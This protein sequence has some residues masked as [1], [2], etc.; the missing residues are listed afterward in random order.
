MRLLLALLLFWL[1]ISEAQIILVLKKPAGGG[2]SGASFS[3]DFNRANSDSLGA[4]WTEVTGDTDITSNGM[5][6][7]NSGGS[8][9]NHWAVYS[10]T[11]TT[12]VDQYVKVTFAAGIA[13]DTYPQV[14]FR[15]TDASSAFYF[16]ELNCATN[17]WSWYRR[18]AAA[19]SSTQIGGTGDV[20][21]SC[22]SAS[23]GITL[24]GTATAT[25]FRIWLTPTGDAP[26][27]A[28]TWGGDNTPDI[29]FT[30]DPADAVDAGNYVGLGAQN[31]T[32]N[33]VVFDSFWG[34]D[35]P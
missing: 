29:S 7:A 6:F 4:S 14:V 35:I 5:S 27:A 9:V 8:Y 3:D 20:A 33:I 10:G 15:Y 32:A 25:V 16:L 22:S 2:G 24:A 30:T 28:D 17:T 12:T 19:G 18:S 1:P 11:A 34:G 26:S 31:L 23:F 21:G 13:A